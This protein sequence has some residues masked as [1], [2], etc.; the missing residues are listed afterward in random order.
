MRLLSS[1]NAIAQGFAGHFARERFHFY[2]LKGDALHVVSQLPEGV[3]SFHVSGMQLL[4]R[5]EHS[6]EGQ[7]YVTA[8]IQEMYKKAAPGGLLLVGQLHCDL[9]DRPVCQAGFEPVEIPRLFRGMEAF[10]DT[11]WRRLYNVYQKA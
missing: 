8:L 2:R 4:A 10:N 5:C 11:N 7:A 6:R 9:K 1:G 3:G